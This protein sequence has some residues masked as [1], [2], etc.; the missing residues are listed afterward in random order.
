MV[1]LVSVRCIGGASTSR[2]IYP[3]TSL[4]LLPSRSQ[5]CSKHVSVFDHRLVS[6]YF[7]QLTL[8]P[9]HISVRT[10]MTPEI[11][12]LDTEPPIRVAEDETS[13]HEDLKRK[14]EQLEEKVAALVARTGGEASD[15]NALPRQG[16]GSRPDTYQYLMTYS[17]PSQ[18]P[19]FDGDDLTYSLWRRKIFSMFHLLGCRDAIEPTDDPV[20]IGDER[21]RMSDLDARHSQQTI[22]SAVRAWAVLVEAVDFPPLACRIFAA[23][24]PS[25][26]W[27]AIGHW[28]EGRRDMLKEIWL[29]KFRTAQMQHGEDPQLYLDRIDE[30]VHMLG[31]LDVHKTE[32]EVNYH[33]LQHLSSD[34]DIEKRCNLARCYMDPCEIDRDGIE[35]TL[36]SRYRNLVL[37]ELEGHQE[38]LLDD[39]QIRGNCEAG[40]R[41]GRRRGKRR[42]NGGGQGHG[43]GCN[44]DWGNGRGWSRQGDRSGDGSSRRDDRGGRRG[45]DDAGQQEPYDD[46]GGIYSPQ[47]YAAHLPPPQQ[48]SLP[49]VHPASPRP[50]CYRC[51]QVGHIVAECN[52]RV[53]IVGSPNPPISV[54]ASY[55]HDNAVILPPPP[56]PAAPPTSSTAPPTTSSDLPDSHYVL[57]GIAPSHGLL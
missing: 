52:A 34:Y 55:G 44:G 28:R 31:S 33:I 21:V 43:Q 17:W 16:L 54:Y 29:N 9:T 6:R 26:A 39:S 3:A 25:G 48:G 56:Q 8:D 37:D 20:M 15:S 14:I 10:H 7:T 22:Q 40:G 19:K 51:N 42:G 11:V 1:H 46:G 41:R 35:G 24:S 4:L 27:A 53:T 36:R 12:E 2:T 5:K 57:G 38:P 49:A 47:L 32:L 13:T 30:A 18:V 50:R 45:R 23:G